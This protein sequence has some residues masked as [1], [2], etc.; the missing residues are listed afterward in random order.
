M[1]K[2]DL[3]T[4]AI[5]AQ[6]SIRALDFYRDKQISFLPRT[7]TKK[8]SMIFPVFPIRHRLITPQMIDE[9]DFVILG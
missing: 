5:V 8:T 3:T 6:A 7:I 4:R 9:V 2:N 1:E